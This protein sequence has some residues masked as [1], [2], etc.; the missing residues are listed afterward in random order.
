[1]I[2]FFNLIAPNGS[3]IT[4]RRGNNAPKEMRTNTNKNQYKLFRTMERLRV[5]PCYALVVAGK[6]LNTK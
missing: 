3:G 6:K 5:M 4:V 2:N 1:M